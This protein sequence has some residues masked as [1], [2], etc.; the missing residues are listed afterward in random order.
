MLKLAFEF[1][2]ADGSGTIDFQEWSV[3][4]SL[5]NKQLGPQ[6]QLY[7]ARELFAMMDREGTG[8][9]DINDFNQIFGSL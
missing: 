2:D 7:D 1:L 3:G 4:I 9:I 6:E 5:L 8:S